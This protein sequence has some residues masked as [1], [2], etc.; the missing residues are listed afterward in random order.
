MLTSQEKKAGIFVLTF[1]EETQTTENSLM[2]EPE[3]NDQKRKRYFSDVM[4]SNQELYN[5]NVNI[6]MKKLNGNLFIKSQTTGRLIPCVISPKKKKPK[7][8]NQLDIE[9]I[10][11]QTQVVR[12]RKKKGETI[13]NCDVYVGSRC[14]HSGWQ[15]NESKWANPFEKLPKKESLEKYRDYILSQPNLKNSLHE[16]KG[17]KIGCF[18]ERYERPCHADVLKSLVEE[19]L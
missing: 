17:K 7:T 12:I 4:E 1:S 14:F 13:Q 15:L 10:D 18:C 2:D 8:R 19:M 11:T 16:L 5:S 3:I 9:I 6:P